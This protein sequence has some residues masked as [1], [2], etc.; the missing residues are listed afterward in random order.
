M[1]LSQIRQRR[2]IRKYTETSIEPEKL[3]KIVE[4]ILRSPSSR[5]YNPWEFVVVTEKTLLEKLSKT[6]SHGSS[7]LK[8]AALGIVIC[9]DPATTDTWIE[10]ATI[11]ALMGQLAAESLGLGSCWIQIR[12]RQHDSKTMAQAYI[13]ELLNI[14]A[15]L[16][17]ESV[18]AIGYAAE[19]KPVKKSTDLQYG[20]VKLNNYRHPYRP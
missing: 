12:A 17:V 15:N 1:F 9:A 5:G 7:F 8:N 13:A 10:D 20:K 4:T 3:E 2:S 14:P 19:D 16:N 6:K 11:A 18:I